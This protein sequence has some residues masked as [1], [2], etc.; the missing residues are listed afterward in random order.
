MISC[1][2]F[3]IVIHGRH[4]TNVLDIGRVFI[5][6][7]YGELPLGSIFDLAEFAVR[8]LCKFSAAARAFLVASW[9]I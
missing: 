9:I 3:Q 6:V 5:P 2:V 7:A 1:S 8:I 4:D